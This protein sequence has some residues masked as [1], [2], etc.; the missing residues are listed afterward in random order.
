METLYQL[1]ALVG[2]GLLVWYT[3]RTVSNRPEAFRGASMQQSLK[4]MGLLA[5][6]LI[7]FVAFLVLMLKA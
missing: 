4:T 5:I 7:L 2:A 3:Y 6:A 1:L